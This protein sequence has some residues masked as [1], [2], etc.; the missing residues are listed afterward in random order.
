M[1]EIPLSH[2]PGDEGDDSE[3][4]PDDVPRIKE[5]DLVDVKQTNENE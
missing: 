4:T 1:E 5:S 3:M 2:D